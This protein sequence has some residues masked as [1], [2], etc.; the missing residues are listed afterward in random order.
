[1]RIVGDECERATA[2]RRTKCL[3][4]ATERLHLVRI[5]QVVDARLDAAGA[6]RHT[7]DHD[8]RV[9]PFTTPY[10]VPGSIQKAL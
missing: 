9:S 8:D 5:Q 1:M 10:C 3:L 7:L 6:L 2:H 4:V